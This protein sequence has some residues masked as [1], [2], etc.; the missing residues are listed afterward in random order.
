MGRVCGKGLDDYGNGHMLEWVRE[1][2]HLGISIAQ[3]NRVMG[4]WEQGIS[5]RRKEFGEM[6]TQK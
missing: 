2:V 4:K 1:Y 6:G 3:S 5:Y